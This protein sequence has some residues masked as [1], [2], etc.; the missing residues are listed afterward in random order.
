MK[1]ATWN[2]FKGKTEDRATELKEGYEIDIIAFQETSSSEDSKHAW[3]GDPGKTRKGVSIWCAYEFETVEPDLPCSPSVGIRLENS[4]LGRLNI[5]NLWAKPNPDYYEDLMNSLEAY[6]K[7]IKS[8]PT[9]IVGDFNISPRIKG[10]VAKFKKLNTHLDTEY[11]LSS[12]YHSYT[13]ELFGSE[14][15]ATLYFRWQETSVFHCDYIYV[16]NALAK[17][18]KTIE[19]PSFDRFDTSDHRPVIC[20]FD[21]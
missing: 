1:I 7:F 2:A 14:S 20:E 16:P 5:L 9:I 17:S 8:A 4:P 18:I 21:L 6:D 10:K 3:C 12:A 13:Q 11:G 19:V 15:Q